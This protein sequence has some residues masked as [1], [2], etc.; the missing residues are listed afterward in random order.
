MNGYSTEDRREREA[1]AEVLQIGG[2]EPERGEEDLW[3]SEN[4]NVERERE[5]ERICGIFK[6][7]R[8]FKSADLK[9]KS[10]SQVTVSVS[11]R[12]SIPSDKGIRLL[13]GFKMEV[14]L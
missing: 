1:E 9:S 13:Y 12:E 6:A 8:R 11:K 14:T 4:S 10:N 3:D 2:S 5:R 7:Q